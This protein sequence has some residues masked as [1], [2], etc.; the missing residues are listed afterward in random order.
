MEVVPHEEERKEDQVNGFRSY[1]SP[2]TLEGHWSI[3]RS[4]I[5]LKGAYAG[6]ICSTSNDKTIRIWLDPSKKEKHFHP[7]QILRGHLKSITTA[8]QLAD[9]RICTGS[10]DGLLKIWD[11]TKN[12]TTGQCDKTMRGH[13]D[14][15]NVIILLRDKKRLCSGSVDKTL[16]IWDLELLRSTHILRGHEGPINSIVETRDGK[17]CSASED[18][19]LKLWNEEPEKAVPKANV[20]STSTRNRY[21]SPSA[22][23]ANASPS[24]ARGALSRS[25]K[26]GI[27]SEEHQSTR[28][29]APTLTV[30]SLLIN[31]SR[32]NPIFRVED[33][34]HIE[35]TL[36]TRGHKAP[37]YSVIQL[38]DGRACS[39][40]ADST[41]KLWD[42]VNYV[43]VKTLEG[44]WT[45]VNC[46]IQLKDGRLCSCSDDRTIKFW[47]ADKFVKRNMSTPD[48][49]CVG[50]IA[51]AHREG[52]RG[53]IELSSGQLCSWSEDT[54]LRIWT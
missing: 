6:L 19:T 15:V 20:P 17:L 28:K 49:H 48:D 9:D 33:G 26:P 47:E 5:E 1:G 10:D 44:H 11:P 25:E 8:V 46:V 16:M 35:S 3:V 13:T 38:I 40:S 30:A 50:T 32:K 36:L 23:Q 34:F 41:I 29:E 18:C 31:G 37:V 4:A 2:Q 53:V 12:W 51:D 45:A 14:A 42:L 22:R 43:C 24:R 39:A 27:L 54:T 21:A 52:I 7:E